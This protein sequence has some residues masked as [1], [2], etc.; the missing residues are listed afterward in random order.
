MAEADAS[1]DVP[2]EKNTSLI[3]DLRVIPGLASA[4]LRAEDV[5]KTIRDT[6]EP[7]ES[8]L[9]A[10]IK[11]RKSLPDTL[12]T[13][14]SFRFAPAT[15]DE[16][17]LTATYITYLRSYDMRSDNR[18]DPSTIYSLLTEKQAQLSGKTLSEIKK[19]KS[20]TTMERFDVLVNI[21]TAIY[22]DDE[23]SLR[24]R[25]YVYARNCVSQN[26]EDIG[27]DMY[28]KRSALDSLITREEI[29]QPRTFERDNKSNELL[30]HEYRTGRL[31]NPFT[32]A[33]L[34][35]AARH[36]TFR[37]NIDAM[38]SRR[39]KMK[40]NTTQPDEHHRAFT[41]LLAGIMTSRPLSFLFDRSIDRATQKE[42]LSLLD[43]IA[44]G[45]N[46]VPEIVIGSGIHGSVYVSE[47][48]HTAPNEQ[49]LVLDSFP[50]LGGQ[51]GQVE[52]DVHGLNSRERPMTQGK[53]GV[54]GRK[55]AL[56]AQGDHAVIHP[57][58]LTGLTYGSN[59]HLALA[60]R[61]NGF[62]SAPAVLNVRVTK[63]RPVTDART[64]KEKGSWAVTIKE[65]SGLEQEFTLFTRRII[66]AGGI[67]KPKFR[68]NRTDDPVTRGII[69]KGETALNQG[70]IPK[71]LHFETFMQLVGDPGNIFP[72]EGFTGRGAIIGAGD[73]GNVTAEYLMGYGPETRRSTV[74]TDWP[75]D[76]TW[77]G[78]ENTTAKKF[79]QQTRVR[80]GQLGL[81]MKRAD[82]D[83]NRIEAIPEKID[84][85]EENS[86]GS[87]QIFWTD[88]KGEEKSKTVDWVIFATG[89]EDTTRAIF[90][91]TPE[92]E[93]VVTNRDLIYDQDGNLQDSV[94]QPGYT[95]DYKAPSDRRV[96][97]I[98]NRGGQ[99][100]YRVFNEN[101]EVR[102]EA[103]ITTNSFKNY[104]RRQQT[105]TRATYVP[106]EKN[107]DFI[108]VEDPISGEVIARQLRSP[109]KN[110]EVYF[111][112]PQT[113]LPISDRELAASPKLAAISENVAAM[114]RYVPRTQ[115]TAETLSEIAP[116]TSSEN[117][118]WIYSQMENAPPKQLTAIPSAIRRFFTRGSSA[119]PEAGTIVRSGIFQEE[120]PVQIPIDMD[121][122]MWAQ[123]TIGAITSRYIFPPG[124]KSIDFTITRGEPTFG[125]SITIRP[126]Q[127]VPD[128][129]SWRFFLRDIIED[130]DVQALVL[131]QIKS[132]VIRV[133]VDKKTGERRIIRRPEAAA[134]L[135]LTLLENGQVDLEKIS[136]RPV[137]ATNVSLKV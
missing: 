107:L 74:Q 114:F 21:A 46:A 35:L 62:L 83:Y 90:T 72:R 136:L 133:D 51:F 118:L 48:R 67:G 52:D 102:E 41:A 82:Y 104:F 106:L 54:P 76:I 43:L 10:A 127:I 56:N 70:K 129:T 55:G 113:A 75:D 2:I 37:R 108:N 103:T 17:D 27:S 29:P 115:R 16:K 65:T 99:I 30:A 87:V 71:V 42:S 59:R 32:K 18:P 116:D 96:I 125:D 109:V 63:A 121:M 4:Q 117:P 95:L 6:F 100:T 19:S 24:N 88:S 61:I 25:I 68:Y 47:R 39:A 22:Q 45:R 9:T 78:Q 12:P 130:K 135:H 97:I 31:K 36:P 77:F 81:E 20:G 66:V 7:V 84:R 126:R 34:Y 105:A 57:G 94:L 110:E 119:L 80:Y 128:D 33:L 134:Q 11:N 50:R 69:R 38:V 64:I 91:P 137:R 123:A 85:L 124:M 111:I 73:S 92:E 5:R 58:D 40:Q 8:V 13:L 79:L 112:G 98:A 122:D 86:D 101:N 49:R 44:Q 131:A 53:P 28:I 132:P 23:A 15:Q 89:Y 60:E 120:K 93:Q 26:V 1:N 3:D 14:E